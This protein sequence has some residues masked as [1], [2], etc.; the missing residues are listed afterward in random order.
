MGDVHLSFP[1][2][3]AD[4]EITTLAAPVLSAFKRNMVDGLIDK[5]ISFEHV[6]EMLK[7][8]GCA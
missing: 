6:K 8:S 2:S 3:N 7:S 5:R 4:D 1:L